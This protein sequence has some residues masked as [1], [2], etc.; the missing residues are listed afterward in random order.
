[1]CL[2]A[3]MLALF[4]NLLNPDIIQTESGRIT[5]HATVRDAVWEERGDRWCTSAPRIDRTAMFAQP[6]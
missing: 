3:E 1:M 5:V 4:L 2:S 6:N